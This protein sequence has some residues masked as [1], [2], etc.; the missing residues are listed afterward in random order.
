M[1]SDSFFRM[2]LIALGSYAKK[3][4]CGILIYIDLQHLFRPSEHWLWR[5]FLIWWIEQLTFVDYCW[6]WKEL[7]IRRSRW[8]GRL[9]RN[10]DVVR[11]TLF[12]LDG[13]ETQDISWR[14][15]SE[16]Q[17]QLIAWHPLHSKAGSVAVCGTQSC[18]WRT[19]SWSQKRWNQRW[20]S[21]SRKANGTCGGNWHWLLTLR[22]T[23]QAY[24][25]WFASFHHPFWCPIWD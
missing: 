11:A 17:R 18:W 20:I 23:R 14:R 19:R 15:L 22:W 5:R 24:S 7:I 16:A 21:P 2:H 10:M 6:S 3:I 4:L 1:Q 12:Q 9:A 25:W 8:C 13:S